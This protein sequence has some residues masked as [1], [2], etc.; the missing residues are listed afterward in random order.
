[1]SSEYGSQS[2]EER[3]GLY[4]EREAS[5]AWP[6]LWCMWVI[7]MRFCFD[8][9]NTGNLTPKPLETLPTFLVVL[10]I[11]LLMGFNFVEN[12]SGF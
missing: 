5:S 7:S 8:E 10:K 3:F 6:L 4:E 2:R 11:P 12:K 1:M 9:R